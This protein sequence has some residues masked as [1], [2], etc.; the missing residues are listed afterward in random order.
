MLSTVCTI[1]AIIKIKESSTWV[2]LISSY[3]RRR[4]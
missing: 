4:W 3:N 1:Y 2:G